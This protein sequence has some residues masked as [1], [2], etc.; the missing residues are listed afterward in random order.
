MTAVSVSVNEHSSDRRFVRIAHLQLSK[1]VILH[2][3]LS[4]IRRVGRFRIRPDHARRDERFFHVLPASKSRPRI[5]P[6]PSDAR[7]PHQFRIDPRIDM[8]KGVHNSH[9]PMA[10]NDPGGSHFARA[11]L[12]HETRLRVGQALGSNRIQGNRQTRGDKKNCNARR[13]HAVLL[14]QSLCHSTSGF[15]KNQDHLGFVNFCRDTAKA[16]WIFDLEVTVP[17]EGSIDLKIGLDSETR[18]QI[19]KP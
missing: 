15:A 19:G 2:Q 4:G 5:G 14:S 1:A 8:S 9:F 11:L 10:A 6:L 17:P 16:R 7:G 3:L 13:S 18:D 12:V